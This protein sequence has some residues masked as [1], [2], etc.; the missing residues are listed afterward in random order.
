MFTGRV[1]FYNS[2]NVRDNKGKNMPS[3]PWTSMKYAYKKKKKQCRHLLE[4]RF[5]SQVIVAFSICLEY[6]G[7]FCDLLNTL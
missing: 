5:T 3:T 2:N 4:I 7:D 6:L 1:Y